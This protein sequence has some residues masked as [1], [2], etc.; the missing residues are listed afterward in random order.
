MAGRDASEVKDVVRRAYAEVAAASGSDP[1]AASGSM[2]YSA[3]EMEAVPD[4]ANLGLG[5]GNP[6]AL[7]DVC[8]GDTV[9][10]LGSGGGFDCFLAAGAVGPG[11]RVIGV[12]L[13][14]EMIE[15]ARRNAAAGGYG[16]VE[17]RQGDLEA[18]PVDDETVDL[19]ISNCVISLVPDRRQVYREAYRVLRP[20]GRLAV[21]DTLVTG[22]VPPDVRDVATA[23][24]GLGTPADY[25]A[26]ITAAGF[27]DVEVVAEAPMPAELA[28]EPPV[29][30]ALAE[31]LGVSP[32]EIE[33]AAAAMVSV[34]VVAVKPY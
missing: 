13:T 24:F 29:A 23:C 22:D 25:V 33:R 18:L 10:D 19:V 4:G 31:D 12:D 16:N 17:F 3:G 2:G 21:S 11:G 7:S 1:V 6:L 20:G 32:A 26:L 8:P 14:A 27:V 30:A 15:R 5:C 9:L 34:S 28:F